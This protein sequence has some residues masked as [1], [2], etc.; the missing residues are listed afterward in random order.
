MAYILHIADSIAKAIDM[1]TGVGGTYEEMDDTAAKFL[2]LQPDDLTAVKE[3][4]VQHME[5]MQS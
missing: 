5:K 3:E 2:N 1:E 4:V